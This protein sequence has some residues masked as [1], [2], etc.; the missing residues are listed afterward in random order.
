VVTKPA[1]SWAAERNEAFYETFWEDAPDYVRHNPGARHRRRQ[2]LDRISKISATSLLDVGCGDGTLLA[3]ARR[4]RPDIREWAG[5]D[6]SPAQVE[7]NRQRSTGVD[8]YV[9]DVEKEAIGRTF[10]VVL[11]S[12]VIEH[13]VDQ[14]AAVSHLARMLNPGGHLVLTCP[15]G[16][17]YTTEEHF[18]HVRHPTRDEL[19]R[20]AE[21]AGLRVLSL[22]NWGWPFY[23]ALK[24]ATNVNAQWSLK[25]FAS[26]PYS[27]AAKVTSGALYWA[28]YANKPDDTR[29]C[30]L[31]G[32]FQRP[33]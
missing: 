4:A 33:R 12:E 18:G 1:S 24:W 8:F 13:L 15:T 32:V 28:N 19:V 6:I 27:A 7:R 31:V 29:G 30:Q 23:K 20:H 9:L 14:S 10:D 11:C 22:H 5:A 2:I 16:R 21:R 25:H 26:G 3:V 17:M